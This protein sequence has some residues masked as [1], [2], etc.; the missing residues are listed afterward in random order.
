[1]LSRGYEMIFER[2]L[3]DVALAAHDLDAHERRQ[4]GEG[5]GERALPRVQDRHPA[6]SALRTL[7]GGATLMALVLRGEQF[8]DG[9]LVRRP[10]A[11]EVR[12]A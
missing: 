4:A 11:E 10:P 12:A 6:R 5:P 1:M 2:T 8:V 3:E 7:N 9:I